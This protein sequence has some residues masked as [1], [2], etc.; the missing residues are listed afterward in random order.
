MIDKKEFS[1]LSPEERLKKLKHLEEER[2]KDVDEIEQ[3]IKQSM[4]EIRTDKLAGEIAPEQKAVDISRLFEKEKEGK[5]EK[6]A[7]QN[8]PIAVNYHASTQVYQAYSLLSEFYG[9]VAGGSR[10]TQEQLNAIGDMGERL[11][12]A[13][14]YMTESER[15][16][17]K[18]DAGKAVLYKLRKATGLE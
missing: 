9:I 4:Q 11:N 18:L 13:E 7:R 12:F 6:T 5:L 17:S 2:K 1:R 8:A 15:T 10:L 14:K 3:L 16:S